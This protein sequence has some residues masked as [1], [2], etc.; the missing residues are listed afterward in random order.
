MK[1]LAWCQRTGDVDQLQHMLHTQAETLRLS[2]I[3][4]FFNF[5]ITDYDD[6]TTDNFFHLEITIKT[7]P[8]ILTQMQFSCFL[9]LTIMWGE[10]L[11]WTLT[12]FCYYTWLYS[13]TKVSFVLL[14]HVLINYMFP[15]DKTDNSELLRE[16]KL[17]F[18]RD[19][20]P[21]WFIQSQL[22]SPKI[23]CTLY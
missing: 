6:Y 15:E 7:F 11:L 12:V 3:S 21:K 22:V 18:S 8:Y 20:P 1:R 5:I 17:V 4:T 19:E 16:G 2:L 9:S 10:H 23:N 14:V 13:I